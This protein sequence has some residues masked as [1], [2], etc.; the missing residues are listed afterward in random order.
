MKPV[1]QFY[2]KP[3]YH[4]RPICVS[5]LHPV[6]FGYTDGQLLAK[7]QKL[8]LIKLDQLWIGAIFWWNI[9]V[10]VRLDF[11]TEA[12]TLDPP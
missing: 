12:R 6:I 8:V 4:R 2:I 10:Y 11:E 9:L 5:N 1:V 7:L 3:I